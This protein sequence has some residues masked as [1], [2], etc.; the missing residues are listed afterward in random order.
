MILRLLIELR[1]EFGPVA[2][3]IAGIGLL[4][5][6]ARCATGD[7]DE[8]DRQLA[9]AES[10]GKAAGVIDH[11]IEGMR[12]RQ[13]RDSLLQIDDDKRRVGIEHGYGHE[14][15]Y[16]LRTKPRYF[17]TKRRMILP[18]ANNAT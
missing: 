8:N 17:S 4:L 2:W 14:R 15:S 3:D 9:T 16:I 6:A 11:R 12:C 1:Q 18:A 13:A 10:I 5:G 7:I